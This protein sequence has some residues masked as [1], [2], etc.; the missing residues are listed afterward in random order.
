MQAA[1]IMFQKVACKIWLQFVFNLN[2][3]W[4]DTLSAHVQNRVLKFVLELV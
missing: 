4:Y 2:L 3:Q 1:T